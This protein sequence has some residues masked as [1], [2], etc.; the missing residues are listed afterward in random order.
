MST[1]AAIATA[2]L[3]LTPLFPDF[4][5][6]LLAGDREDAERLGGFSLPG[7]WPGKR[8]VS[9][10]RLRLDQLLNQPGWQEWLVRGIVLPGEARK[11][12]GHIGFHG[13]PEVIGR[14]ELGYSILPRHRRRGYAAEAA[15]A[16]MSWAQSEHGITRFYVSISPDNL[17]SL[18]M[19]Q[20]LGFVLVGE[21]MD[22]EDGLEHVFE[23]VAD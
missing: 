18:G 2:R 21:Q 20:K 3:E 4:L 22:D 9:F 13:P 6:A 1:A 16:L 23:L 11:L 8:D 12:I 19:A 15:R 5:E 7:D 10:L 17:P 14:A